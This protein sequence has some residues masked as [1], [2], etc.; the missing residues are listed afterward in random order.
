MC[1]NSA[2]VHLRHAQIG[3]NILKL[4]P[5]HKFWVIALKLFITIQTALKLPCDK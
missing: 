5:I 2:K 3:G 4:N 1:S